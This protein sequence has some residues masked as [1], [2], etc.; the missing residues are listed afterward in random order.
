MDEKEERV[1][2]KTIQKDE[3]FFYP[4]LRPQSIDEYIGQESVKEAMKIYM[5]AAQGRG[6]CLEHCLFHGPSRGVS[7]SPREP[8]QSKS[9][10]A[11][12][13]RCLGSV[14]SHHCF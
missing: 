2:D 12:L 8:C 14:Y 13:D 7:L 11:T 5:Q 10:H 1:V 4:L 3:L 9:L 6:E